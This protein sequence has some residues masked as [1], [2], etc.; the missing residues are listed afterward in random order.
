MNNQQDQEMNFQSSNN[1]SK[2]K[3]IYGIAVFIIIAISIF[4]VI[5]FRENKKTDDDFKIENDIVFND[6]KSEPVK[7]DFDSDGL[8]DEE[9]ELLGTDKFKNDTDDD[10]YSDLAE[11]ENGYDPLGEG[12]MNEELNKIAEKVILK[13]NRRLLNDLIKK[14]NNLKEYNIKY[15]VYTASEERSYLGPN[16]ESPYNTKGGVFSVQKT[17]KKGNNVRI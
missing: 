8:F 2:K 14:Y 16:A 5:Y 7:P 9:E 10:G 12:K 3:L 11:I 6:K 1:K 13:R 4:L 17:Y 15:E